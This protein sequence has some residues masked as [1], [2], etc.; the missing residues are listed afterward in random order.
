MIPFVFCTALTKIS[1]A[2]TVLRLTNVKWM[3]YYMYLLMGSLVLINGA[4]LVVIFSFCRPSHAFWD[5]ATPHRKCWNTK[6]LTTAS[7]IQGGK[8]LHDQSELVVYAIL[9]DWD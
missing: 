1:I 5:V 7:N 8:F 6:V 3:M 4:S 9:M 2:F